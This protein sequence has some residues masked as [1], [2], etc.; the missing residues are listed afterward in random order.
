MGAEHSGRYRNASD[1][2]GSRVQPDRQ[3]EGALLVAQDVT[4]EQTVDEKRFEHE[5]PP[6]LTCDKSKVLNRFV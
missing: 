1:R 2:E 6:I 5:Y 4:V 3:R